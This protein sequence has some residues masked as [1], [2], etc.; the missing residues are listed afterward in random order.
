[1]DARQ[2]GG[3]PHN[4]AKRVD[5]SDDGPFGNSTDGRIARHLAYCFEILGQQEGSSTAAGSEGGGLRS[6]VAAADDDDVVA[7]HVNESLGLDSLTQSCYAGNVT[8]GNY[9]MLVMATD[10]ELGALPY[11]LFLGQLGIVVVNPNIQ[12]VDST[13]VLTV[14][15]SYV[16]LR[17][18]GLQN[19]RDSVKLRMTRMKHMSRHAD[20]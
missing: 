14:V 9:Q 4:T 6:C 17:S 7:F 15:A 16:R 10:A 18:T 11:I 5:L 8:A 20:S 2:V 12:Q 1:L 13:F 3:S 19:Y